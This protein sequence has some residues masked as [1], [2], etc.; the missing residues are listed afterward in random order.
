ML[1]RAC[2]YY[3]IY[4][5]MVVAVRE[6]IFIF[7]KSFDLWLKCTFNFVDYYLDWI[8]HLEKDSWKIKKVMKFTFQ[9]C[10]GTLNVIIHGHA[11]LAD[12]CDC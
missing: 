7:Q 4:V 3:N 8:P 5:A 1:S 10:V 2:I 9:I 11:V 12:V 6:A